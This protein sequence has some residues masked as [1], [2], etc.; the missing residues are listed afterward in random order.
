MTF[1]QSW[2]YVMHRTH[3]G[4]CAGWLRGHVLFVAIVFL[5]LHVASTRAAPATEQFHRSSWQLWDGAP[6]DIWAMLQGQDG[7][8][9]LGTG[10]GL[11]RFDG[12]KFE[13]YALPSGQRLPSDNI[14]AMIQLPDG[15]VWLGYYSGGAGVI[16]DSKLITYGP[17]DGFPDA[18]VYNFSQGSDGVLWAATERGLMRFERGRWQLIG[19]KWNYP[20]ARAQWSL[21]DVAGN[22]WVATGEQLVVLPA[23][24]RQFHDSGVKVGSHAVLAQAPDSTLWL[25]DGLHGTRALPGLSADPL[26]TLPG[27]PPAQDG[28]VQ[29]KR[30]MFDRQG[31]L[32]ATDTAQGGIFEVADPA[33]ASDGHPL[34][35]ADINL[36]VD[37]AGGLTADFAVPLL[38]DREGDI[39]VGTNLG[40]NSLR[41][42]S[43]IVPRTI[44]VKPSSHFG[45]AP[46]AD[47]KVWIINAGK[48]FRAE[49]GRMVEVRK[50]LPDT[51][52]AQADGHGLLWLVDSDIRRVQDGRIDTVPWP[53]ASSM[54]TLGTMT[55]DHHGG[56]WMGFDGQGIQHFSGAHWDSLALGQE[57][58]KAMP[59]S[60]GVDPLGRLWAGYS[61]N[62]VAVFNS[63]T[64]RLFNHNDGLDIGKV[65]VINASTDDILFGGGAGLARFHDGEMQSISSQKAEVLSGI[66]GI[67]RSAN[68]DVWINGSQGVVRITGNA[69]NAAFAHPDQPF[70]YRLFDEQD[71]LPGIALQENEAPTAMADA[72]GRLWF[73][74][75]QGV[76]WIDPAGLH[77]N[78]VAPPVHIESLTAMDRT[79]LPSSALI[80]PKR[81]TSVQIA[82]T[83]LSLSVPA[84]VRFRYRL[85][86]DPQWQEAGSRRDVLYTHLAPG[87]H[88]FQVIAAN[89]DGVWNMQGASIHFSIRPMFYQTNWFIALV[90]LLGALL[91]LIGFLLRLQQLTARVRDRLHERHLERERI[92]RELHDTLLQSVQGLVLRF[93]AAAERLES[94]SPVRDM[95]DKALDRADDLLIEG[96]N[97]VQDLRVNTNGISS[98]S[99]ALGVLGETLGQD[100]SVDYRMIIEG[101]VRPLNPLVCDEVYRIAREAV[102]NAF[103]HAR[104]RAIEVEI[105]YDADYLRVRVRDDGVGM[106]QRVV[107]D[108]SKPGHWGLAGMRERALQIGATLEIWGGPEAGTELEIKVPA[109]VAY[110]D[111][112]RGYMRWLIRLISGGRNG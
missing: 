72:G 58:A 77:R 70:D 25:S 43:F 84:R 49:Q 71:G 17:R 21:R 4:I 62:R 60:M 59:T 61:R 27:D 87:P 79:W 23:G 42:N 107:D 55:P 5:S 80:F 8:L 40:L 11:Y 54:A 29:A 109:C 28:R 97:R 78:A 16:Q 63:G 74:T 41:K 103:A 104:A 110:R 20:A 13:R 101:T 88:H 35:P 89:D 64:M 66:S 52:A 14:T 82:Y 6:A 3:R 94:G 91:L 51:R 47:G 39:W 12:V 46:D 90:V 106:D 38:Q 53:P 105:R 111:G 67:V 95:I 2:K 112:P 69:L 44:T 36:R 18:M 92:A 108:G 100:L 81:T 30:M 31:R 83:A 68:G 57:L 33:R 102:A 1:S 56:L 9:W 10:G 75:N 45:A 50:D 7:Y 15:E 99:D 37:R 32:W 98:L 34:Q 19:G 85:D 73:S 24:T 65:A 96:R 26:Q 76:A 86:H 22:L 48:L 93:Q